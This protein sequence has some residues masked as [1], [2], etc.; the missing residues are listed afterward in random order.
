M[1]G[2]VYRTVWRDLQK[3]DV[4]AGSPL[5]DVQGIGAYLERRVRRALRSRRA[6]TVGA[7]WAAM[8]GRS[9]DA[10][11]QWLYVTLQ[12]DRANQ[13]VSNRSATRARKKMYHTG[14]INEF[15]YAAMSAVLNH[16]RTVMRGARYGALPRTLQT[17][18]RPSRTC[19][20]RSRRA[21]SRDRACTLSDD[22][23]TCVPRA[24]D[25]PGFL[26]TPP[27]PDQTERIRDAVRDTVRVQRASRTRYTPALRR[28]PDSVSDMNDGRS[29]TLQY[30]RRGARLWRRPGSKVRIPHA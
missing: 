15:G 5:T 10:V 19:G 12:N 2:A 3:G 17:R 25:T 11:K 21:C 22:R 9:T 29:M 7:V 8:R 23:T 14:D 16:G 1:A 6:T 4:D 30:S 27:H 24:N 18:G 20:C 28:D 13:C 26:G